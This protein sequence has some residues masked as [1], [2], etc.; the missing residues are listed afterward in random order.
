MTVQDE[1]RR[2]E[3]SRSFRVLAWMRVGWRS[4]AEMRG[5]VKEHH[6]G[7]KRKPGLVPL[8]SALDV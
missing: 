5:A 1:G 6:R 3:V 4:V 8:G 7:E 2:E